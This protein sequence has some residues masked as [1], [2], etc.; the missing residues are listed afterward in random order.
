MAS[1]DSVASGSFSAEGAGTPISVERGQRVVCNVA[2]T[3]SAT[4]IL[5][6]SSSRQAWARV[7]AFVAPGRVEATAED[8]DYY[9]VRCAAY[10]SGTTTYELR[11][12]DT[13]QLH[14]D[15]WDDFRFPAAGINPPGAAADPTRD[16]A[17]GCFLFSGT[18][19]NVIAIQALMPHTWK[20]GSLVVPH[21]HWEKPTP[22][23]GAVMWEFK[24][25]V[26]EAGQPFPAQWTTLT[27]S[28]PV[29]GT[30]DDNSAGRHLITSF[31]PVNLG[32][33]D[34]APMLKILV[35]RL[36]GDAADTYNAAAKLLEFDIHYLKD[37]A[38]SGG[39]FTK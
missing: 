24:Y 8:N 27:A 23:A 26:A 18:N 22:A 30:P 20:T 15:H 5:E 2:G 14:E 6:R 9:R 38:G 36:P 31:G 37:S 21:V 4:I 13:T 16:T 25:K 28:T 12:F 33:G 19:T 34:V 3:F 35:S 10:G 11:A 32:V 7:H 29:S 1:Y 39:E 17:D